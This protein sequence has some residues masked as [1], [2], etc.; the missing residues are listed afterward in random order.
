MKILALKLITCLILSLGC[1][2]L[3]GVLEISPLFAC[4]LM[5]WGSICF[6]FSRE[7]S[8]SEM[9]VRQGFEERPVL[10]RMWMGAGIICV[11]ITV[12][13]LFFAA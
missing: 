1:F 7:L 2:F 6:L 9:R 8:G 11:L 10:Q 5:A 3:C 12:W 13:V 4:S